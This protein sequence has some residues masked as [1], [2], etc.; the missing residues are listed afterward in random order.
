M[1]ITEEES[2]FLERLLNETGFEIWN[3]GC[4]H[5][6]RADSRED[7]FVVCEYDNPLHAIKVY[8]TAQGAINFMLKKD[9][10]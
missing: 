7:G 1:K 5:R 6:M 9:E 2:Y 10:E 4:T 8:K 3:A